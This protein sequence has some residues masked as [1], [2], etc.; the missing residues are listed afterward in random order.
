[1]LTAS[2]LVFLHCLCLILCSSLIQITQ[3]TL[4]KDSETGRSKGF[5]FLTFQHAED[6]KK[7]LEQLN[8]FELAGRP[9]KVGHVTEKTA[10]DFGGGSFFD[11]D[12]MDRAGVDLGATGRLQLMAKLAEG[13]GFQIPQAAANA[14]NLPGQLG[15][16]PQPV[17][18]SVAAQHT[19]PPIATQCFMLS[20]MFEPNT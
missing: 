3:V 11:N 17:G 9:M 2:I 10:G 18:V 6:A 19:T 13:T 14:L 15:A 12:E 7:A 8:G 4:M 5:G 20:N 1:M 16:P